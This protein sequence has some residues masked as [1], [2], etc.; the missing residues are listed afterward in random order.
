M[1]YGELRE[2]SCFTFAVSTQILDELAAAKLTQL[3]LFV[4]FTLDSLIPLC[5][6]Y[7]LAFS[8]QKGTVYETGYNCRRLLV[9]TLLR[10]EF[11][12]PAK[13]ALGMV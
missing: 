2:T 10:I 3:V 1:D 11:F 13:A 4:F 6:L 12:V 5:K 7:V 9:R 8:T